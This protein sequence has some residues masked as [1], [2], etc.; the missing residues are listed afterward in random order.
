M[1]AVDS[2]GE[3]TRTG[4][5]THAARPAEEVGVCQLSALDGILQR[6]GQRLLSRHRVKGGGA[7]FSG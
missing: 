1:K 3:D 6:R 2:L 5:L 7:V 4:G